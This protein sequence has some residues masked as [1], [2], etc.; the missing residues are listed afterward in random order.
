MV[1]MSNK[2]RQNQMKKNS[3]SNKSFILTGGLIA[4]L[5][6]MVSIFIFSEMDRTGGKVNKQAMQTS[7]DVVINKIDIGT[8][9]TFYPYETDGIEL[10]LM[11]VKASDG[12][13]RTAF[14][15]CQICYS[16]GRGYYKQEGNVIVCQNCRNTFTADDVQV[17]AGGCNPVPIFEE[18]KTETDESITI[19]EAFI[20]DSKDIFLNWR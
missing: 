18:N 14:N 12:T 7:G 20:R 9:A 11:A 4:V 19:S 16:S 17:S 5:L 8:S 15:T 13:I 1:Y 3:N 10:E 6:I 2:K